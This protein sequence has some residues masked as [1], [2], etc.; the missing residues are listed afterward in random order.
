[1]EHHMVS[2]LL[3][4]VD[5]MFCFFS[6]FPYGSLRISSDFS[7]I[8][9]PAFGEQP[10]DRFWEIRRWSWMTSI[11]LFQMDSLV[12]EL[13]K[14]SGKLQDGA[15]VRW[16][17]NRCLRTVAKNGRYNELVFMVV[18]MIS[19]TNLYLGGIILYTFSAFSSP[20]W[21]FLFWSRLICLL[22]IWSQKLYNTVREY[23]FSDLKPSICWGQKMISMISRTQ[24]L[25]WST[26]RK[27][28]GISAE[29]SMFVQGSSPLLFY[30]TRLFLAISPSLSHYPNNCW[31][32]PFLFLYFGARVIM[33]I[34]KSH[35]IPWCILMTRGCYRT[36]WCP[37]RLFV[38][39]QPP[40][41]N[42]FV[43][44]ISHR[45]KS[46]WTFPFFMA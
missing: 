9:H 8:T 32:N 30:V 29:I 44:C 33:P 5:L 22:Y 26:E 4:Q 19:L 12:V 45:P 38:G 20:S 46:Y 27:L 43:L 41:T 11:Q 31:P 2:G 39:F 10:H 36:R 28:K 1:M 7:S 25:G 14:T 23:D 42:L 34:K 16:R 40:L 3:M 24:L 37:P 35:A 21:L 13:G 15:P 6:C 18:V 17:V